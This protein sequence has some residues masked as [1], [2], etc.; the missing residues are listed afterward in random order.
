MAKEGVWGFLFSFFIKFTPG[1]QRIP[2]GR[3]YV[4]LLPSDSDQIAS[5]PD[6]YGGRRKKEQ[7]YFPAFVIDG[8]ALSPKAA[9][10]GYAVT[11]FLRHAGVP[12]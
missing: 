3:R 12:E 8:Q 7:K 9:F 2:M 11:S 6:S 5:L 10:P 1:A 4:C